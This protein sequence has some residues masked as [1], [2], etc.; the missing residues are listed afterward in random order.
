MPSCP[1]IFWQACQGLRCQAKV[2]EGHVI[3]HALSLRGSNLQQSQ[4]FVFDSLRPHGLSTKMRVLA[5]CPDDQIEDDGLKIPNQSFFA[6]KTWRNCMKLRLWKEMLEA[7][8]DV[9]GALISNPL[10]CPPPMQSWQPEPCR[11][12]GAFETNQSRLAAPSLQ[13]CHCC[14]DWLQSQVGWALT[15]ASPPP[16]LCA[17][18]MHL[19]QLAKSVQELR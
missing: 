2:C 1:V 13:H 6:A 10:F 11:N 9:A 5:F 15:D 14:K 17:I 16:V 19:M 3:C 4:R 12:Y 7:G 18:L 8:A